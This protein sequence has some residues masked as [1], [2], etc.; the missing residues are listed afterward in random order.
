MRE[1]LAEVAR[2]LYVKISE[3]LRAE[4][5]VKP[6]TDQQAAGPGGPQMA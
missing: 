4:I 1:H 5:Q 3:Q 2:R 6:I